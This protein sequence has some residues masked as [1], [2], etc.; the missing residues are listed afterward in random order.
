MPIDGAKR[1]AQSTPAIA[2]A[3][4]YGQISSVL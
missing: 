3:T 4:A 1:N 2:G